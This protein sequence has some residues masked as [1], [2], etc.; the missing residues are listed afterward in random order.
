[1]VTMSRSIAPPLWDFFLSVAW[2]DGAVMEYPWK[3]KIPPGAFAEGIKHI[4][5]V[6]P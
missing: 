3:I 1:M 4:Y 2:E 5:V 6:M